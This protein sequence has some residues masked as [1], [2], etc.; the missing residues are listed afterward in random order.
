VRRFHR[1]SSVSYALTAYN[2]H[3]ASAVGRVDLLVRLSLYRDDRL[4]QS[5]PTTSFDVAGQ[6]D[7]KRLALAGSLPLDAT[8]ESGRYVLEVAVQDNAAKARP[9]A[10]W[11]D[12]EIVD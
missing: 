2:A 1:G 5:I 7:P 12:F 9:A 4:V 6:S 3:A 8:M 11:M 10:Q